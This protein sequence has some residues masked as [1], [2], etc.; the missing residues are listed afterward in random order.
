MSIKIIREQL[1][2]KLNEK[3]DAMTLKK[4]LQNTLNK[5][6]CFHSEDDFKHC[7]AW[8]IHSQIKGEIRLEKR[9]ENMDQNKPGY[10]DIFISLSPKEKFGIELKYKTDEYQ[11]EVNS[12]HYELKR[13]VA[14]NES[15]Y[16]F[17]K[18]IMRL[19]KLV[20]EG[21]INKG[22]AIFLTND[23]LY[24]NPPS[25]N[26]TKD[27]DFRIHEHRILT[28]ELNWA[29]NA[30]QVKTEKRQHCIELNGKYQIVWDQHSLDNY[31]HNK[32]NSEFRYTIVEVS[33]R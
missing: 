19:E 4:C 16:D 33:G 12:E 13:H 1:M 17:C 30:S 32:K 7:L 5:Y 29:K 22:F 26:H 10:V 6:G 31:P 20:E 27:A 25:N 2:K 18:D 28:G 11:C 9:F 3:M 15:R 23:H 14:Y 8:N 21:E 24:W